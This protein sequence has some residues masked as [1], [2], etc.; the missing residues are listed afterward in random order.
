MY[1]ASMSI[2]KA[3]NSGFFYAQLNSSSP[4]GKL[5]ASLKACQIQ[6]QDT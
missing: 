6:Q 4:K 1:L 2:K 3:A 5:G